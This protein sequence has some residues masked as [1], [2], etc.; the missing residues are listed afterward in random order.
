MQINIT[1]TDE[2]DD[3]LMEDWCFDVDAP[4][5]NRLSPFEIA[6]IAKDGAKQALLAAG[7]QV[8]GD[9]H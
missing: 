9:T 7:L 5:S 2:N 8:T 6:T 1:L 4:E 3:D